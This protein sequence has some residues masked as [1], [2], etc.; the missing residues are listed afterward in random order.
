MIEKKRS[1]SNQ[2][3]DMKSSISSAY[4]EK[5]EAYDSLNYYSGQIDSWYA[6]S[7]RTPWLFGNGGKKIPKHSFF[8]Q[9]H[10]DLS[11]YKSSRNSAYYDAQSAKSKISQLKNRRQSYYDEINRI[12]NE[13]GYLINKINHAKSDRNHWYELKKQGYTQKKLSHEI[14]QF[15]Q[16]LAETN[17]KIIVHPQ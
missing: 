2:V 11:S 14:Q 1:L 6:K 8:G 9:S 16:S 15:E 3:Q 5:K 7:E 4:S 13:I 10:G 12:S 17:Q